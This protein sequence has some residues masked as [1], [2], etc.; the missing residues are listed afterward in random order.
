MG[1]TKA[2][3]HIAL[4]QQISDPKN[5]RCDGMKMILLT[6]EHCDKS[7]HIIWSYR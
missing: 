7:L 6:G 1:L 4:F 3:Y 2:R 5:G